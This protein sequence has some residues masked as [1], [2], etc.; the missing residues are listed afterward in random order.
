MSIAAQDDDGRSQLVVNVSPQRP[1]G[2]DYFQNTIGKVD[3][4]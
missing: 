1:Q 4:K 3:K 2:M